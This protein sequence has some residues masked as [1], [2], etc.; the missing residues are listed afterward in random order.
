MARA[1]ILLVLGVHGA[2]VLAFELGVAQGD[3]VSRA[4]FVELHDG[5]VGEVGVDEGAEGARAD[6]LKGFGLCFDEVGDEREGRAVADGGVFLAVAERGG[7]VADLG[8]EALPVRFQLVL[9]E[10][11]RGWLVALLEGDA[12]GVLRVVAC[13]DDALAVVDVEDVDVLADHK[14][15]SAF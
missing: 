3:D 11:G 6:G 15:S 2:G 10:F 7:G 4:D 8:A 13:G 14:A 12:R 1:Q 9:A 5:R